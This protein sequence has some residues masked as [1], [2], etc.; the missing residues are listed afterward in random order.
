MYM[1]SKCQQR[2]RTNYE[3]TLTKNSLTI[4]SH[5]C[6]GLASNT[7]STRFLVFPFGFNRI[8][9]VFVYIKAADACIICPKKI[10]MSVAIV[11][12]H[13]A[14]AAVAVCC[15]CV[16]SILLSPRSAH[17]VSEPSVCDLQM[18]WEFSVVFFDTDVLDDPHLLYIFDARVIHVYAYRCVC[19]SP[20][21]YNFGS[22]CCVFLLLLRCLLVLFVH[23]SSFQFL[24]SVSSCISFVSFSLFFFCHIK[25][26]VD[27]M[28]SKKKQQQKKMSI[29]FWNCLIAISRNCSSNRTFLFFRRTSR[30]NN[31]F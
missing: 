29:T 7:R 24:S 27:V 22:V 11:C 31:W 18:T 25:R 2:N 14:V 26:C 3:Y 20:K 16:F 13:V 9:R 10:I 19:T 15:C 21:L 5:E 12:V 8:A 4:H 30:W 17:A 23:S 1:R 6:H 28:C